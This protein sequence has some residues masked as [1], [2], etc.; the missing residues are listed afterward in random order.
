[1]ST[2]VFTKVEFSLSA[3]IEKIRL[4]EIGLPDI[5]RPFVWP[6]T[7]V[8]NLFD[9]MLK[10]FPVG[11][12]LFWANV[13]PEG[14][15]HVGADLKQRVPS[16]LIVDGQQRLTSL[17]AVLTG[18]PIV[19][20][21]YRQERI[22]IAFRPTDRV[23]DVT[24]VAIG[25]DAEFIPDISQLWVGDLAPIRFVS[26]FVERL[27]ERRDVSDKEEDEIAAAID[28]LYDLRN[29][30]FTALELSSSVNEE[31]VGDIFVRINSEGT[32]LKQA[33]FIL[34]LMSV[35]WD[36]GRRALEEFAR[37]ARQSGTAVYN[38]FMS[39]D[40]DQ[41]LRVAVALAFRRARLQYVYSILRGK[42]L[43][44]GQFSAEE[45]ERQ[46]N[47]LEEAQAYAL[48]S[49][50]WQEFLKTL[51]RAGYRRGNEITSKTALLYTYALF[52]IG[53]R[54]YHLD[55]YILRNVV[56]RWFFMAALTGRYTS[57]P[58]TIMDRDLARLRD[59]STGDGFVRL[60]DTIV[61]ETLTR[62]YWNIALPNDLATS[63]PR[64]PS[65]SGYF[66]ALSLL[67]ARVLFSKLKV[68][69]LLDPTTRGTRA[70]VEQH[71]LFP[72]AYLARLGVTALSSVNQIANFALV[73][74][75][76]NTSISD[77]APVDYWPEMASR[78]ASEELGSMRYW[79]AIPDGWER[80]DYQEFL[81]ARRRLM[82]EVIRDGF[83]ELMEDRRL[84]DEQEER[85][86]QAFA[87]E[88]MRRSS[89]ELIQEGEGAFVE[90]K[91]SARW[92]HIAGEKEKT[93]EIEV[94][95]AVAGF[96]NAKGGTL[97]IGVNDDG[98]AV[99]LSR[100]YK[101]LQRRPNRDGFENWLTGMLRQ[102]LGVGFFGRVQASFLTL[103]E[104]E[105][106][107]IDVESS[108]APLFV[109]ETRFFVRVG[110]S[111]QELRAPQVLEY[112]ERRGTPIPRLPT[113]PEAEEPSSPDVDD[114]QDEPDLGDEALDDA[115]EYAGDDSE[116][117]GT[118]SWPHERIRL[119]VQ[120][121]FLARAVDE[122][123]EW[124]LQQGGSQGSIRH[125]GRSRHFF[126]LGTRRFIFF[127]FARRWMYFWI[128]YDRDEDFQA[129]QRLSAPEQ[130]H[131]HT[132][133]ISG[134]VQS[135]E[136]LD[137]LKQMLLDR[138]A[139]VASPNSP[140]TSGRRF[141]GVDLSDLVREGL[142]VEGEHLRWGRPTLNETHGA[143]VL[144]GGYGL[145]TDGR[146]FASPSAAAAAIAGRPVDGW[147]AWEA[148]RGTDWVELGALRDEYLKARPGDD[149]SSREQAKHA[150]F[151]RIIDAVVASSPNYR[152]RK[153]GHRN[154]TNM[155]SAPFGHY[156]IALTEAGQFRTGVYIDMAHPLDGA[157][158]VFDAVRQELGAPIEEE[159]RDDDLR[160]ERLDGKRACRIA[161]Y[162]TRP[163][164]ANETAT[165]GAIQW[166]ADRMVRFMRFDAELRRITAPI[167]SA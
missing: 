37:D 96:L 88:S 79:H 157:K 134:R 145:E 103:G 142:L 78:F 86:L 25:M 45:R 132:D 102:R 66:A 34:T 24:N 154:W 31:D 136:D 62:D 94:A 125:G 116:T 160:W 133:G 28:G 32:Q 16:S 53:R 163:D 112:L 149:P 100:D 99:G 23:F 70:S 56:A 48:D 164:L 141:F 123:E 135:E 17:Y 55:P 143:V 159:F 2:T 85:E 113:R 60:L 80:M 41:M 109:D 8:R 50:H 93:S 77:A 118:V 43:E 63:A 67:D 155:G 49:Q 40:P 42:D 167:K 83:A 15:R 14:I 19:R 119:W 46:F 115:D 84:Q 22:R 5:Q 111:T 12:L 20:D 139:G 9:S 7:K 162:A 165:E 95:R 26:A 58:E 13:V 76:D 146:S 87:E 92:S 38:H 127:R 71:H 106:C 104:Q 161:V 156:S 65:K 11:Y 61:E 126:K 4:G 73:E 18:T 140:V 137:I 27:R 91:E 36:K 101:S 90:F 144:S 3:L 69:E 59:V 29:Y 97:F 120:S 122:F 124:L 138:F 64:S 51:V 72:R 30:P 6:N 81:V 108:P 151:E 52:L 158:R 166:A 150:F 75:P 128:P 54:D 131:R 39:P 57:S 35:W 117:A 153:A 89:E 148:Q 1:M 147:S 74:W 47:V 129:L 121:E 10:G 21:D 107:R 98:D 44:T 152:R 82:A 130:V 110:N 114:D 105:I 68:S 33:D